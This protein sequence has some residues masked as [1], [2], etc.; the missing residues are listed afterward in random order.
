MRKY[1]VLCVVLLVAFPMLALAQDPDPRGTFLVSSRNQGFATP[2][3]EGPTAGDMAMVILLQNAGYRGKLVPDVNLPDSIAD[4][5]ARGDTLELVIL[6]GSSSSGD[7]QAVPAG[8]AAMMGEHV[9]LQNSSRTGYIPFYTDNGQ[10]ADSN[11]W[12]QDAS[13]TQYIKIVNTTHPIT[14]GIQTDANGMVKILRDP[15][16]TEDAYCRPD[17][18]VDSTTPYK[19]NY[20]F[21]WPQEPISAA[22]PGLTVLAVNPFDES[23]AVFAVLDKGA[24]MANGQAASARYVHIFVNDNGSGGT[25]RRFIALNE[26]GRLLFVRAA[27]WALGDPLSSFPPTAEVE[28]W[29]LY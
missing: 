7:V 2:F 14:Q 6:S 20:E 10:S 1:I 3:G 13:K 29:D 12:S 21:A 17:P 4:L 8:V 15:Y 5:E 22:A 16:P 18:A 28:N 11:R 27:Q 19:K 25:R 26:T 9:T 23:L 24:T